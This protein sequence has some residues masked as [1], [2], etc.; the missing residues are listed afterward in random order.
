V[1]LLTDRQTD[2]Q[3][4][5]HTDTQTIRQTDR[6][7]DTYERR[8][9]CNLFGGGYYVED[10]WCYVCMYV[11]YDVYILCVLLTWRNKR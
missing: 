9:K 11:V 4:N 8:V 7:T 1:K 5:R 2:R 3:T 10:I 6:H